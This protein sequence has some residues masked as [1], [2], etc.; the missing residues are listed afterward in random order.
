MLAEE[1]VNLVNKICRQKAEE[2]T[3]ELKAAH[4]GIPKRLYDTLSSFSNQNEG[5]VIVF[6]IDESNDYQIVGV[7]D[8]QDLQKKVAEQ[9]NQ[10]EPPV[11][12][13]FTIAE[14]NGVYVC[15]CEIP[16]L[17]LAERP[18]YYKG[19]GKAN[20]SFIRVGDAD[21]HMTDHEI[22]S[23]EAFRRHIHDDERPVER[24]DLSKFD[25]A[26]RDKYYAYEKQNKEGFARMSKEDAYEM[27]N[28]TKNGKPT[29]AAVMNFAQYPQGYF[30]QLCITAISVPGT[31]IGDVTD[32]HVRFLD[33]QRIEGTIPEMFEKAMIFCRRNMKTRT[34]IDPAT[35]LQ[36]LHGRNTCSD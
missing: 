30:P 22:Y 36:L 16:S 24:A 23:F 14:M 9:C 7:Y 11:R 35:G 8:P 27:M 20:G 3:I 26:A 17:E 1:L 34:V 5:G 33:N 6:G 13:L 15:S 31:A 12:G 4:E 19:A 18:C 21:L 10:M 32:D 2:Q 29:L 25:Q 28:I